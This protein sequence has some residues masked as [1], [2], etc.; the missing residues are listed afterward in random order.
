M[1]YQEYVSSRYS[2]WQSILTS[3]NWFW[4]QCEVNRL[5]QKHENLQ[6]FQACHRMF[7]KLDRKKAEKLVIIWLLRNMKWFMSK[8]SLCL[9]K[10]WSDSQMPADNLVIKCIYHIC[11]HIYGEVITFQDQEKFHFIILNL[12]F[13]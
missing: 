11:H 8:I 7:L 10:V 5:R 3:F 2:F 13:T 1:S 6:K 4:H 9:W 12:S